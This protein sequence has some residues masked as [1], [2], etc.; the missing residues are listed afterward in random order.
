MT[1]RLNPQQRWNG[2]NYK[3]LRR[4][5]LLSV[6]F[7]PKMIYYPRMGR[8]ESGFIPLTEA[9]TDRIT[10]RIA[11]P[12]WI[13]PE[14]VGLHV[15]RLTRIMDVA[16]ID[17]IT[18]CT[19]DTDAGRADIAIVGSNSHGGAYAGGV[20]NRNADSEYNFKSQESRKIN[21]LIPPSLEEASISINMQSIARKLDGDLES[22]KR[23]VSQ[24]DKSVRK[25]LRQRA[26]RF[27]MVENTKNDIPALKVSAIFFGAVEGIMGIHEPG[28]IDLGYLAATS[29]CVNI[30]I[31]NTAEKGKVISDRRFSLFP[32]PQVDRAAIIQVLARTQKLLTP[33]ENKT[34]S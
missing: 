11:T 12:P 4:T 10:V 33:I 31:I 26:T 13:R 1:L 21:P 5:S 7:S 24:M 19:S 25:G 28:L 20:S 29:F 2:N 17:N 3:F 32:G 30:T 15:D 34:T 8:I 14:G 27:L 16:A 6:Y 9:Q 18:L 22:N 23:W